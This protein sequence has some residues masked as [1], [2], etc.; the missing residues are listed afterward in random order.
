MKRDAITE[1][2]QKNDWSHVRFAGPVNEVTG[3]GLLAILDKVGNK[4]VINL[5]GFTYINSVGIRCWMTFITNLCQSRTVVLEECAF[6]FVL[7]LNMIGAL[8]S[9]ASVSSVC[10]LYFCD[11][12]NKEET[13]VYKTEDLKL[14]S[15][16]AIQHK[17]CIHCGQNAEL[18]EDA[19]IFLH[20][21]SQGVQR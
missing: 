21:L 12:C 1:I 17:K 15:A 7:Q 20:F 10:T 14:K 2:T 4:V 13:I 16:A 18:G 19:D 6:E 11:D 5:S 8:I 3:P 9:S